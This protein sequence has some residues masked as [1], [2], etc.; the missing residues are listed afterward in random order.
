MSLFRMPL[1][2][3]IVVAVVAVALVHAGFYFVPRYRATRPRF[4]EAAWKDAV[5]MLKGEIGEAAVEKGSFV[6]PRLP[7]NPP[8]EGFLY[9]S[10]D[11]VG[12]WH[13]VEAFLSIRLDGGYALL[14]CEP[15]RGPREWTP[16]PQVF[17]LA[18]TRAEAERV[19]ATLIHLWRVTCPAEY[20][21]VGD[22][23]SARIPQ[24]VA[25]FTWPNPEVPYSFPWGKRNLSRT[26][27]CRAIEHSLSA[28]LTERFVRSLCA[29]I[30]QASRSSFDRAARLLLGDLARLRLSHGRD[31]FIAQEI[32][33]NI[34]SDSCDVSLLP[35]YRRLERIRQTGG[36]PWRVPR[37]LMRLL[38]ESFIPHHLEYRGPQLQNEI[39]VL[40]RIRR[41]QITGRA[42]VLAELAFGPDPPDVSSAS[43]ASGIRMT[44]LDY[45][46]AAG[47]AEARRL[48]LDMVKSSPP[49]DTVSWLAEMKQRVAWGYPH[50][51]GD[52]PAAA[53]LFAEDSDPVV[54]LYGK[55]AL[56]GLEEN[57]PAAEELLRSFT[58]VTPR[59]QVRAI[60][61][62]W[63]LHFGPRGSRIVP[64]LCDLYPALKDAGPKTRLL[65]Y[66]MATR[67]PENLDFVLG[68]L[69]DPSGFDNFFAS[70]QL[71]GISDGGRVLTF[72]PPPTRDPRFTD[73]VLRALREC[74]DQ[75]N[76]NDARTIHG[77]QAEV[78]PHLDQRALPVLDELRKKDVAA[79][80]IERAGFLERADSLIR[81]HYAQDCIAEI[82]TLAGGFD[83]EGAGQ[84]LLDRYSEKEL[85]A[86]LA[87]ENASDSWFFVLDALF[88]L[89]DRQ[90]EDAW[91]SR[92]AGATPAQVTGGP[93]R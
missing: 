15:M 41:E 2:K 28:K 25:S 87:D 35:A 53:R 19:W 71:E 68:V 37:W 72:F 8:C 54:A 77:L 21:I 7:V 11:C 69:S 80:R 64:F 27:A 86:V 50:Y 83:R 17:V 60:A 58:G 47:P 45:L 88:T 40:D 65:E 3:R 20:G 85:M 26:G 4:D 52:E 5:A 55:C 84:L 49:S 39:Y 78:L 67:A 57:S 1:G 16:E 42:K 23:G 91:L 51:F 14:V 10:E 56:F 48:C 89:H 38:P 76:P 81:V 61:L 43:A 46:F 79:G 36:N 22:S 70:E 75:P 59:Y 29:R 93:L 31:Q 92:H 30:S 12:P 9:A 24:S 90:F 13:G 33:G 74:G 34:V 82:G 44:A 32:V 63:R 18:F 73:I 6:I 66:L 62:L